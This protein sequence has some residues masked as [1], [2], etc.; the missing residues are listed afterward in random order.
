MQWFRKHIY[1]TIIFERQC[2]TDTVVQLITS[3]DFI[4]VSA[5]GYTALIA[6]W[7]TFAECSQQ[8]KYF[9]S[10]M[11]MGTNS[12]SD[13]INVLWSQKH[14]KITSPQ[15]WSTRICQT[16]G[17]FQHLRGHSISAAL[18][19]RKPG[20]KSPGL[21][22]IFPEFILHTRSALKSWFCDF[23]SS[24]MCQL[25]IPKIW[26]RALIVVIPKPEKPKSYCPIS[27][28]CVPFKIIERFIYAWVDSIIDPLLLR[29]EVSFRHGRSAVD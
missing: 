1:N 20:A 3:F 15:G 10:T 11:F 17:R 27:L 9:C 13:V 7:L 5:Y 12:E 8:A 28:L 25:K 18:R 21:D 19:R 4:S 14:P 29:E 23:L 24:C 16:Y 6:V 26:R 22:S 2:S